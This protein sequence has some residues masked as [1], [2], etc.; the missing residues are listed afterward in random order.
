MLNKYIIFILGKAMRWQ[1]TIQFKAIQG[2]LS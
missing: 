1:H 2:L